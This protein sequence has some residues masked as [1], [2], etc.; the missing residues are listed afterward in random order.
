MPKVFELNRI[1][2]NDHIP[3]KPHGGML[4]WPLGKG[5]GWETMV[6]EDSGG[7]VIWDTREKKKD[8]CYGI[9]S[10]GLGW[11]MHLGVEVTESS[12]NKQHHLS[13]VLRQ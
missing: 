6:V 9:H 4:S 3:T 5:Q 10:R 13:A 7:L 11:R 2:L 1:L 12:T 8:L